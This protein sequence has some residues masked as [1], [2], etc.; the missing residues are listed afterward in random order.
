MTVGAR[1]SAPARAALSNPATHACP[2][3]TS[4]FEFSIAG[5]ASGSADPAAAAR[6]FVRHSEVSGFGTPASVWRVTEVGHDAATVVDLARVDG[7]VL[8]EA[9]RLT[10]GTWVIDS[11]RRCP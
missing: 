9:I 8:L 5:G 6:W 1:G 10:D 4:G 7:T 11:G 3:A 2:G